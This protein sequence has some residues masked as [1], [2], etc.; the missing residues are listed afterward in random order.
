MVPTPCGVNSST[1]QACGTRP[2]KITAA[3]APFSI[4]LMHVSIFGIIPPEIVP[5]SI[6]WRAS[7]MLNSNKLPFWSSTPA[8]DVGHFQKAVVARPEAGSAIVPAY[9]A[10]IAVRHPFKPIGATTS[11]PPSGVERFRHCASIDT[12]LANKTE[13][14]TFD[15]AVRVDP[16][17][18]QFARSNQVTVLPEMPIARP[19]AALI[20]ATILLLIEPDK[21]ISTIST[22]SP[23]VTR[24]PSIKS[25]FIVRRTSI[26]PI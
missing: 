23:S 26:L 21:T 1:R 9:R 15:I 3:R 7:L 8:A 17:P 24:R 14:S 19:P 16:G 13:I 12:R 10:D 11:N 22:V 20:A 5:L 25:L 18:L 4:A 6:S 2:S